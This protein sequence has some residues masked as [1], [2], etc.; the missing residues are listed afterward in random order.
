MVE[1]EEQHLETARK[2]VDRRRRTLDVARVD[3]AVGRIVAAGR[4]HHRLAADAIDRVEPALRVGMDGR[5]AARVAGADRMRMCAPDA[6]R[7][8]PAA[9]GGDQLMTRRLGGQ[10]SETAGL[11]RLRTRQRRGEKPGATGAQE[12]AATHGP[13]DG[14]QSIGAVQRAQRRSRAAIPAV[15]PDS[16][17]DRIRARKTRPR[18]AFDPPCG[19]HRPHRASARSCRDHACAA[20]RRRNRFS[21]RRRRTVEYRAQRSNRPTAVRSVA[22]RLDDD[23]AVAACGRTHPLTDSCSGQSRM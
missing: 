5:A 9:G 11:G 12:P 19:R 8:E 17:C 18:L 7:V 21:K 22:P 1:R 20:Q 16:A 14:R 6:L 15:P 13:A 10:A 23:E 2:R 4:G 3:R